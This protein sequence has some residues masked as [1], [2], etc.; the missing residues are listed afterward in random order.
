M[1]KDVILDIHI[2]M[3]QADILIF[4]RDIQTTNQKC[5]LDTFLILDIKKRLIKISK[6]FLRRDEE[7]IKK[8]SKGK[9]IKLIDLIKIKI[10]A[11]FLFAITLSGFLLTRTE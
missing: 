7:K 6:G 1:E 2:H 11:L 4:K 8:K 9:S 10:Y 5:D 3:K